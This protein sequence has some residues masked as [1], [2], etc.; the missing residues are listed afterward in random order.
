MA[1]VWGIGSGVWC[2]TKEKKKIILE[3]GRNV[4]AMNSEEVLRP[5]ARCKRTLRRLYSHGANDFF[6]SSNDHFRLF[7]GRRKTTRDQR[8]N[9][10]EPSVDMLC[11]FFSLPE[12][13][14]GK[15][16]GGGRPGFREPG[17]GEALCQMLTD[18]LSGGPRRE[19]L[20]KTS[21]AARSQFFFCTTILHR[22][23]PA[24]NLRR[25]SFVQCVFLPPPSKPFP[26]SRPQPS[27]NHFRN[28]NGPLSLSL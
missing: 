23:K 16:F 7:S 6:L 20:G 22:F 13:T 12:R 18:F 9:E 14:I 19:T 21:I 3:M 24:W 28:V 27:S 2:F 26:T 5:G 10:G 25:A 8:D 11:G 15:V 17:N 4:S 1:G